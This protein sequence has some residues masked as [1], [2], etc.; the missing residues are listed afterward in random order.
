MR[1]GTLFVTGEPVADELINTDPLALIIAMLLDQQIP[2]EWAFA[3]PAR[4]QQRLAGCLDAFAIANYDPEEFAAVVAEKPALHRFP[5][6]MAGRIQRLSQHIYDHY[7]GDAA[8]LWQRRTAANTFER[9]RAVPGF[10][11]EKTKIFL[12]VL[13]KRFHY[14]PQGWEALA[15]PFSDEQPRSVADMGSET[16]RAAV[17]SWKKN[18]KAAAKTKLD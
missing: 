12:A 13:A 14:R 15:A 2:I 10:G 7:D 6:L 17:R 1:R 18:Q 8:A 16:Q 11:D 4:L 9:L 5:A 3:G